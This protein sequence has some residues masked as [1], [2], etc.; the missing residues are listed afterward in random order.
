[1]LMRVDACDMYVAFA[2]RDDVADISQRGPATPDHV[3]RTKRLPMLGH[4]VDSY[5]QL[6]KTYF[7]QNAPNARAQVSMLDPAPRIILDH[8]MGLITLAKTA[9]ELRINADIYQHTMQIIQRAEKL[10]QLARGKYV[11]AIYHPVLINAGDSKNWYTPIMI[12]S[13]V[14]PELKTR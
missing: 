6:Y 7:E 8:E 5:V 10:A 1:M 14:S 4:D 3:I 11:K 2:R 12:R 13:K 9:K